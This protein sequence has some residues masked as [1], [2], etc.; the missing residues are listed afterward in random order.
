MKKHNIMQDDKENNPQMSQTVRVNKV[1][2]RANFMS[3]KKGLSD[4]R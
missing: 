2:R 4:V 3:H 1:Q